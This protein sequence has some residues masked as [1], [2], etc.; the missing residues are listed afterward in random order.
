MLRRS[1]GLTLES[2]YQP[3]QH[4]APLSVERGRNRFTHRRSPLASFVRNDHLRDNGRDFVYRRAPK[5]HRI[6]VVFTTVLEETIQ[7]TTAIKSHIRLVTTVFAGRWS[8][9][10]RPWYMWADLYDH[11]GDEFSPRRVRP[12]VTRCH[13]LFCSARNC[14]TPQRHRR[15][16]A[17]AD[18]VAGRT[19]NN[20]RQS[21]GVRRRSPLDSSTSPRFGLPL[22]SD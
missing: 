8:T 16:A 5:L 14:V 9:V 17:A 10:C 3:Q 22:T 6:L 12:E 15:T 1:Y 13:W 20:A 18:N 4:H 7:K 21:L 11:G 19:D 2:R